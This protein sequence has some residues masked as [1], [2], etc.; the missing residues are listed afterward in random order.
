MS[1]WLDLYGDDYSPID[2]MLEADR[3]T[4]P[5]EDDSEFKFPHVNMLPDESE[6]EGGSPL[7]FR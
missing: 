3:R 6:K 4:G 1:I 5:C 2:R 7:K